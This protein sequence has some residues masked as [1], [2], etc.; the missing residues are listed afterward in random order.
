MP[1]SVIRLPSTGHCRVR[2]RFTPCHGVGL[3]FFLATI[4]TV[5]EAPSPAST[6][7][8]PTTQRAGQSRPIP[9]PLAVEVA[10]KVDRI[11]AARARDVAETTLSSPVALPTPVAPA[12]PPAAAGPPKRRAASLARPPASPPKSTPTTVAAVLAPDPGAATDPGGATEIHIAGWSRKVERGGQAT[13]NRCGPAT[14]YRGPWPGSG[15]GTTW[16]A[17][18]SNCG[19]GQWAQLPMGTTVTISGPRGDIAYAIV[20]RTWVPR[21]SGSTRGL[22]HDDLI[23]QTC[24]GKGTALTYASR[25]P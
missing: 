11:A 21:K 24:Q 1:T 8:L 12:A 14:L 16:L 22:V 6:L 9:D 18:H 17:G 15:V 3:L 13:I 25:I 20:S 2:S 7:P 4:L 19:F 10:L 23:L 5:S